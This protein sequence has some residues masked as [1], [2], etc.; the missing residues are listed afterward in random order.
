M[1]KMERKANKH[2][3]AINS[4]SL[5]QKSQIVSGYVAGGE[6]KPTN[7]VF[8]IVFLFFIFGMITI[9]IIGFTKGNYKALIAGVDSDGNICGY[10]PVVSN[11]EKTYYFLNTNNG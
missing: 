4:F 5:S 2:S 6:R 3:G 7:C 9:S 11:L 1:N 10:T 8:C